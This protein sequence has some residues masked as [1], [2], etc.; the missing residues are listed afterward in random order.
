MHKLIVQFQFKR[1]G[2]IL[3]YTAADGLLQKESIKLDKVCLTQRKMV[4]H[5]DKISVF[6]HNKDP[7]FIN[8]AS[9]LVKFYFLARDI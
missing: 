6:M 3:H 1:N 7:Y 8:T 4:A 5:L 9:Q 2:F